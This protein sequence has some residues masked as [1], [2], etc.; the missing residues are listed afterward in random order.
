[1]QIALWVAAGAVFL[2]AFVFRS[3]KPDKVAPAWGL[4]AAGALLAVAALVVPKMTGGSDVKVA[5]ET[6]K[7]GDTVPAGKPTEIQID[8]TGGELATSATDTN[9]GHLHVFVD[10]SVISMPY[11]DSSEVT[12]EPGEHELKVEY[13]DL[14]HA[15]YDPP[16][17]ETITVTAERGT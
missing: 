13:V 1:M 3:V 17:Q 7:D 6:P 4:F 10:G 11:G 16:I 2:A 9:G 15:S 5:F 12:L 14:E 8:L